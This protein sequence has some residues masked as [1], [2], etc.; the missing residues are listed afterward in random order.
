M[1]KNDVELNQDTLSGTR[2]GMKR[3]S[4]LKILGG[5][6]IVFF[7]PWGVPD[8]FGAQSQRRTLT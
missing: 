8:I 3:R 4:F 2:S 5:G 1:K 7:Q 6:I